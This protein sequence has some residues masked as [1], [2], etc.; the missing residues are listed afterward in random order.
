[1]R[2]HAHERGSRGHG[3]SGGKQASLRQR[4]DERARRSRVLGFAMARRSG[5]FH[6]IL[7]MGLWAMLGNLCRFAA[8]DKIQKPA[9]DFCQ[10]D[11]SPG[12]PGGVARRE[13]LRG[14][15]HTGVLQ[16][17]HQAA[18]DPPRITHLQQ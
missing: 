14:S 6:G 3:N 12:R 17:A 2:R 15:R 9:G 13:R 5:L 1:M 11:G 10:P 7:Q 8:I 16:D 18:A 4:H